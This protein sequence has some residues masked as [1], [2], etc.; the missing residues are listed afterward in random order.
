MTIAEW[1]EDA[2]AVLR[3]ATDNYMTSQQG[4]SNPNKKTNDQVDFSTVFS[5]WEKYASKVTKGT[6]D[7]GKFPGETGLNPGEKCELVK[8]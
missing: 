5:A 1:P 7:P 8:P 6:F 3:E 4:P 2:L